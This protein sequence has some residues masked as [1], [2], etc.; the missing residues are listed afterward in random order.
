MPFFCC[1]KITGESRERHDMPDDL[2]V[3]VVGDED[4][5]DIDDTVTDDDLASVDFSMDGEFAEPD[6]ETQD[7]EV[8]EDEENKESATPSGEDDEKESAELDTLKSQ[9]ERLSKD[10]KDLQVALH[11]ARQAKKQEKESSG[12]DALSREQILGI[13][14]EHGDDKDT[15]LRVLEYM[16]D[17]KLKG[18]KDDTL[19]AAEINRKKHDLESNLIKAN[20][21]LADEN[22]DLYHRVETMKGQMNLD[23][24]PF[25]Q[26]LA[27]SA[28][29]SAS[30]P[31]IIE[32]WKEV[33][34][35]EALDTT[36]DNKRKAKIKDNALPPSKKD[37]GDSTKS[38]GLP[39]NFSETAKQL[40]LSK[41]QLAIYKSLIGNKST[42]VTA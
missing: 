34:K 33:G 1:P 23:Q 30:L 42:S 31:K 36:A 9:I 18:A 24:H 6:T 20:P 2:D 3:S 16:V 17:Q 14:N 29:V 40:Q 7:A 39:Q 13:L 26:Y 25:G 27:Y 38:T 5:S 11:Q 10:K 22:S 4:N 15:M 21:D 37:T 35:R 41:K 32:H 8:N 19:N 28:L 12:E